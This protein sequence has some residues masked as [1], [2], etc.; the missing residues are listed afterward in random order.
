MLVRKHKDQ[1]SLMTSVSSKYR[2]VIGLCSVFLEGAVAR[3]GFTSDYSLLH[4]AVLFLLEKIFL[5][6]MWLVLVIIYSLNS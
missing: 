1:K 5:C 6:H 4:A 2:I 3:N